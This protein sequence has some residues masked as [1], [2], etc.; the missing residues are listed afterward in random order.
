V[1]AV[2]GEEEEGQGVHEE[3]RF[4]GV[5]LLLTSQI[6]QRFYREWFADDKMPASR[7]STRTAPE[8][9]SNSRMCQMEAIS[10][11]SWQ[12]HKRHARRE[13][14]VGGKGEGS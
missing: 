10:L 1:G 13:L 4:P 9:G 7:I 5:S 3:I 11:C 12:G 14:V 2:S 6:L 8:N